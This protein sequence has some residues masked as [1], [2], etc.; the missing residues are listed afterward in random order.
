MSNTHDDAHAIGKSDNAKACI[1][2]HLEF[3]EALLAD[4]KRIDDGMIHLGPRRADET[5]EVRRQ[6]VEDVAKLDASI[7]MHRLDIVLSG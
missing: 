5:A 4:I 6:R 1:A 2:S 3:R 7:R